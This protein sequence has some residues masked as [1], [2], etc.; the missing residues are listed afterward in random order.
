LCNDEAAN[1]IVCKDGQSWEGRR[2]RAATAKTGDDNNYD[3]GEEDEDDDG[4]EVLG[5]EG[6]GGGSAKISSAVIATIRTREEGS[7]S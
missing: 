5:G 4:G 6:G 7:T 3:E 1:H 2:C